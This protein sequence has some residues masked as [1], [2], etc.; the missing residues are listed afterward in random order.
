MFQGRKGTEEGIEGNEKGGR[1]TESETS[2]E[3]ESRQGDAKGR[4][5][6]RREALILYNL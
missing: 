1:R 6:R 4:T 3:T 5:S 2:T